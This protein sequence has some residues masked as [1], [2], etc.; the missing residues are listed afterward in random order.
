[1]ASE[2]ERDHALLRGEDA[3]GRD[4]HTPV[5]GDALVER[6]EGDLRVARQGGELRDVDRPDER[7]SDRAVDPDGEV[8]LPLRERRV[9]ASAGRALR[10]AEP[11]IAR[12]EVDAGGGLLVRI[13][14]RLGEGAPAPRPDGRDPE[15]GGDLLR[16]E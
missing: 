15:V 1:A 10:V 4:L 5:L 7:L 9:E 13:G 2:A 12:P 11:L 8:E 3:L 14:T 6:G 16:G